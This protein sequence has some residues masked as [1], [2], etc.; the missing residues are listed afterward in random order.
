MRI[1]DW[2]SDVC[3]SDLVTSEWTLIAEIFGIVFE[4]CHDPAVTGLRRD[5]AG[6]GPVTVPEDVIVVSVMKAIEGVADPRCWME[7]EI[8]RLTVRWLRIFGSRDRT[9]KSLNSNH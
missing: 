4:A 3:S 2:S 5:R 7:E 9:D 8:V 1:S 6:L